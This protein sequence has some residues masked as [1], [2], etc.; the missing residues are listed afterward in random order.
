MTSSSQTPRPHRR[1]GRRSSRSSLFAGPRRAALRPVVSRVRD[2]FRVEALEPRVLLSA[3]PLF[4]PLKSVGSI[5]DWLTEELL[6]D[7]A[8]T[9]GLSGREAASLSSIVAL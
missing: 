4:A 5:D 1:A 3:D 6:R 9:E 2:A 7:A 8:T